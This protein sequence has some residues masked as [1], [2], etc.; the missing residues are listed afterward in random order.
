MIPK[1]TA[2]GPNRSHLAPVESREEL[3]YLLSRASEIE[4]DLACVYLYAGYSLKSDFDEGG[5]TSEELEQ[6]RAWKRRLARV[7]VEEMLHLAQAANMLTAIGGAPHFRRSNFPL[8][9]DAF[10]F[11]IP[12]SLEPFS[13]ELIERLVCYE[14]PEAGVLEPQVQAEFDTLRARVAVVAG[15]RPEMLPAFTGTEPYDIDFKTVGEFYHKIR[16]G[17]ETI[18][19]SR[20]FI[21]PLEA[22]AKAKYLDLEG[23]LIA[24]TDRESACRAI[25]MIVSQGESPTEAHPDAHFTIF[26]GIRREYEELSRRAATEGRR[27]EPVRPVVSN[28]TTRYF[29]SSPRGALIDDAFSHE[30][31]DLFNTAYDTMLLMLLRFF[32]HTEESEEEL[33]MLARGTLRLMASVLRPLGEAL[34]KL[35]AGPSH[36]GKTA[37]PGFGYNRDVHLLAH[38]GSAWIF[39]LERLW[40]LAGR[41]TQLAQTPNVPAEIAEAAAALESVAEH[42]MPYVPSEAAERVRTIACSAAAEPAIRPEVNGPYLVMNLRSLTNSKGE[43]LGTRP[44]VALCRCGG[45][46]LKPYCDGTHA[47]IGFNS[48]KSPQRTQDRLD[49][50]VG[51]EITVRDN[52]GA[53]CHFG[54]CTDHLPS[55]F[56]ERGDSF[57]DPNGASAE[58]I[59][60]IVRACPSGALGYSIGGVEY[61]G[62]QREPAIFV[63]HN[64]PYYVT[65]GI[66][67]RNT[68]RNQGASLEHFALCRCGQSKNKPFCDGTHWWIKFSDDDN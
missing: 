45:S 47:S 38:K 54:N 41:T 51:R 64:G 10:P 3:I 52:R 66:E 22:Q 36:P 46:K 33:R 32:A 25:E 59:I 31:A 42:L 20:L 68:E 21:G 28:P 13:P 14:M 34:T 26:D 17:F 37:A 56:G 43:T 11:G 49:E 23:Q 40:E 39:F 30:V 18:D 35:P 8:P 6:V 16:S 55:V 61:A 7:A 19:E 29:S 1:T 27:F 48:A 53:C 58:A 67:L 65:G 24:V 57:V 62:E 9:A 5:L 60:D 2:P 63:S 44:V 12:V 4:H 15:E 50:Y